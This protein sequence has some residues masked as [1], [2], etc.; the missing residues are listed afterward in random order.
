MNFEEQIGSLE[1]EVQDTFDKS[2]K[3]TKAMWEH[4]QHGGFSTNLDSS[5]QAILKDEFKST[6]KTRRSFSTDTRRKFS[7]M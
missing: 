7:L 4:M 6:R 3:I 5:I 1:L 2:L